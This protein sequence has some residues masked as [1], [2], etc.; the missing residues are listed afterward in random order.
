MNK[1][2]FN[3]DVPF[4][5]FLGKYYRLYPGRRYFMNYRYSMHYM[6]WQHHNGKVPKGYHIHHKDENP[7]NN[8]ITNLE[9]KPIEKHLTDHGKKRAIDN[10][11]WLADFQSKGTD[12]AKSWHKSKAG[13]KWHKEHALKQGFGKLEYGTGNC[14][15]CGVEFI[16]NTAHQLFCGP[17]CRA[18]DFRKRHKKVA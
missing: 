2:K 16:N 18:K 8:N 6:V 9:I 5:I 4:Q 14:G 15:I 7:W 12:A 17:N 11:E 1:T 13:K 10:P 3:N